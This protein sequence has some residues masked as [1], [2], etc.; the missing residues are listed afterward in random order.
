MI[1][2]PMRYIGKSVF[3]GLTM[4]KLLSES[5]LD[6]LSIGIIDGGGLFFDDDAVATVGLDGGVFG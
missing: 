3:L 2:L 5:S 1:L 6:F 4:T